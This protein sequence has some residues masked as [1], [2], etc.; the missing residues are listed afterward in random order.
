MLPHTDY[1]ILSSADASEADALD[2][3]EWALKMGP[4]L[5]LVTRGEAGALA[6]DGRRIHRQ[7]I[8]EAGPVVDT[9]GAGD[10]FA[11]RLMV[12]VLAGADLPAALEMAAQSAA[13]TCSYHGA[14][15]HGVP[16]Q[17]VAD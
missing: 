6:S 14:F 2:L 17:H 1:A 5:V 9:L 3:M 11:A 12:E 10:A 15:G 8:V 16:L 13:E 4:Q 7:P